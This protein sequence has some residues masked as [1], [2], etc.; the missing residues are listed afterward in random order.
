[1]ALLKIARDTDVSITLDQC[2]AV[3]V[4]TREQYKSRLWY[5]LRSGRVTAS[6]LKAVYRTATESPSIS[7]IMTICHPE[8]SK[9]R[10][11]ATKW[12]CDHE[13]FALECYR[14]KAAEEHSH[15]NIQ[16]SGFFMHRSFPFIGASPDGMV[17]CICC[18]DG[19]IEI[20]VGNVITF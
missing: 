17:S 2:K 7:L 20:K 18:G 4:H 6:K 13:S 9:F 10:S 12:G 14:R 3:E 8:L 16:S 5:H 19:V 11:N 15:L 1:M